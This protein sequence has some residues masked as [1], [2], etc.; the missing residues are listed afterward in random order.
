MKIDLNCDMGERED[1]AHGVQEALLESV[2]S[3]N[4]ACG[5][6]AGSEALM[7]LTL[8]QALAHG[9]AVGAHPGYPDRE[10]FGR[11]PLRIPLDE[12]EASVEEQIR[13]LTK[14]ATEE[15]VRVTYVKAHGALYNQAA[16]DAKLAQLIARAT[17]RVSGELAL[18]GLAGSPALGLWAAAGFRVI[19]EAFADRRYESDGSLRPRRLAGAV[20]SSPAEAAEQALRMVTRGEAIASDGSPIAIHAR[21]LCVH[22]DSPGAVQ[23]ARAI[24]ERL[25]AMGV[26]LSSNPD[27]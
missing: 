11:V 21:T 5:A 17:A 3:A 13:A 19:P 8:R 10:N 4:I 2:T 20:L 25:A 9:V 12:L 26:E 24:K 16:Q 18:M 1:L 22:G 14:L 15:G 23:I 7:R 6:H 27:S